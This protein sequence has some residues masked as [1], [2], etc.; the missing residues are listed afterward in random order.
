MSLQPL[1]S[2]RAFDMR[3]RWLFLMWGTLLMGL[4]VVG[5]W[6]SGDWSSMGVI[7]LALFYLTHASAVR[8]PPAARR[9]ATWWGKLQ[10]Q[11]IEF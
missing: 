11:A 6:R 10:A 5:L 7:M 9:P 8:H 4:G 2:W 1:S 3:D